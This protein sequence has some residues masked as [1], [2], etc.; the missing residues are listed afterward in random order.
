MTECV[1]VTQS[2]LTVTPRTVACWASLPMGFPRQDYWKG[3]PC[4][5][6]GDPPNPGIKQRSPVLQA[7]S[8]PSEPPGK[9]NDLWLGN[10]KFLCH[11][12]Y[13]YTAYFVI[14][15]RLGQKAHIVL[16]I[17]HKRKKSATWTISTSYTMNCPSCLLM[18]SLALCSYLKINPVNASGVT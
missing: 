8:L 13:C 18:A 12:E 9:P 7:D 16:L 5:S 17:S 6:R 1:L 15:T 14:G 2:F 11:S 3:L 4:P 10:S